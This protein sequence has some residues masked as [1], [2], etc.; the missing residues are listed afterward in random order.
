MKLVKL[1][2]II[3][4]FIFSAITANAQISPGDL[5]KAHAKFEG[6]SNC[7]KCHGVGNK[8]TREKCLECHK[9]IQANIAANKGYHASKEVTG[10]QCVTC[11]NEHHGIEFQL[12]KL[13]QKT[14][15][16]NK[17]GY[18]LEGKHAKIECIA[19]HKSAF[20]K[21]P[22][23]K[24]KPS[25]YLGLTQECLLCHDDYHKGKL[26]SKCTN[27]HNFDTF[28]KAT[29]F[30]HS[31]TH[32]PLLGEHKNVQCLKCHK[33]EIV[34]GKTVQKFTS[35]P[36][37]NCTPCHED[38][39]KNKFGQ[40][41]K[42][43][44][45]EESF[46]F[47]KS[48]K[49]FDH[50]KTNFKLIGKHLLV[51][52]KKCHTGKSL[53]EPIK[54]ANCNNCHAD[55]HKGDFTHKGIATDCSECHTN[56]GFTPSTFTIEKHNA[57]KFKLEGA[58]LATACAACH[59]KEKD[60]KFKK[61]G[62]KCVDCHTNIHKGSIDEKFMPNEDCRVCHNVINWKQVTFDHN[63]TDY[64]LEGSHV[65]ANC[66]ECH[67]KKDDK[68]IEKQQFEGLSQECSTCHK[69]SH[70]GQF[71]V[72][73]KTD[74][75]KCHGLDRWENSKFDHNTSRFKLDG[76]HRTV[77]CEECHKPVWNEKGKYIEYKFKN[78]E[79]STC[80]S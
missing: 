32:F 38:V 27:C 37:T 58:H 68:G 63:K 7:T 9:E 19:C 70:F 74:C 20:I 8:V 17:A 67:Y 31:K 1:L 62:K 50:N 34:N 2:S 61:M 73:G 18:K 14:F 77:K 54:H 64:K 49:V 13:D 71:A 55:Y 15:N 28:K 10:K 42:Q 76:A 23:L 21:D 57:T 65:K 40:N 80:H 29:G 39:H 35:L 78:I 53:T 44:H 75:T 60:W 45:S 48:L 16:H 3:I 51:D 69:D 24:K 33:T 66:A 56:F 41:C 26:S 4:V 36:F 47:N 11:H 30:D 79:C 72:N 46:A 59:K 6:I 52:C 25:T 43:C 12:I 22:N 5:S